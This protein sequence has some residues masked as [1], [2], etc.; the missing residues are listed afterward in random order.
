M[1]NVADPRLLHEI[2]LYQMGGSN[3]WMSIQV[4]ALD[5][6]SF[7]ILG[8]RG[9]RKVFRDEDLK[10]EKNG[11]HIINIEY[12]DLKFFFPNVDLPKTFEM[13]REILEARK[14]KRRLNALAKD[15]IFVKSDIE[16]PDAGKMYFYLNGDKVRIFNDADKKEAIADNIE[17][18]YG[19]KAVKVEGLDLG[20]AHLELLAKVAG[21]FEKVLRETELSKLA[22]VLRGKSLLN[23]LE[24][25]GFNMD[26]PDEMW[27]QVQGYFEDFGNE[28]DM[29]GFLT[30][31]P[32]KISEILRIPIQGL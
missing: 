15:A 22:L 5:D 24:Y 28:G 17:V 21:P 1:P 26:A 10:T 9:V 32:D 23:G 6:E 16:N 4:T 29:T 31:Y 13:P 11:K 25:Y 18:I 19:K 8:S 12:L 30:C 14:E 20:H 7:T 3:N 27:S 2:P